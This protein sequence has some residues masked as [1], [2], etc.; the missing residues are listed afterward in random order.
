[1]SSPEQLATA[2]SGPR[3]NSRNQSIRTSTDVAE[4]AAQFASL[5]AAKG[6]HSALQYLNSRT[7]HRFT[8]VYRITPPTLQNLCLFDRENPT[9]R[10]GSETP[11]S[12]TYCSITGADRQPFA[13]QNSLDNEALVSHPARANVISYCGVPL[14]SADGTSWGTLCHFDLRPRIVPVGEIPLMEM[15]APLVLQTLLADA[16]PS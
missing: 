10:V 4:P 8:G 14:L 11:L 12:A 15:L 2:S 16:K 6:L 1:M 7:R 3:P 5:M 9:V 13:V